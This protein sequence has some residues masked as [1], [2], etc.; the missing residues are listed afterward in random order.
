V[1][2][3]HASQLTSS[4]T[5][6]STPGFWNIAT[7]A[8]MAAHGGEGTLANPTWIRNPLTEGL[9]GSLTNLGAGQGWAPLWV[10]QRTVGGAS[11]TLAQAHAVQTMTV[12]VSLGVDYYW[13]ERR[14]DQSALRRVSRGHCDRGSSRRSP[15]LEVAWYQRSWS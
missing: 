2:A 14:P 12:G 10:T 13:C 6:G 1:I 5:S 11:F 8:G 3:A 15:S 4:S 7:L 9:S